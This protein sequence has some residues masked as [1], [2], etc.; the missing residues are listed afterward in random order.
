MVAVESPDEILQKPTPQGGG[1]TE[2]VNR[3]ELSDFKEMPLKKGAHKNKNTKPQRLDG[4]NW[5]VKQKKSFKI[6][7]RIISSLVERITNDYPQ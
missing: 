3:K 7:T 5:T 2:R 4:N 1:I 6:C